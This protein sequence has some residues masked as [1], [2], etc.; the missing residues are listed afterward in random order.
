[1]KEKGLEN[2]KNAEDQILSKITLITAMIKIKFL[3]SYV[4]QLPQ[5][6][7]FT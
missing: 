5:Q 6:P 1:M 3:R 7:E 4:I 2:L